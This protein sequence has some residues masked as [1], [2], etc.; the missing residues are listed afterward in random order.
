MI[1]VNLDRGQA[2]VLLAEERPFTAGEL[3]QLVRYLNRHCEEQD[4]KIR[5]LKSEIGRLARRT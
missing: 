3:T 4:N 5:Q 2:T 1:H